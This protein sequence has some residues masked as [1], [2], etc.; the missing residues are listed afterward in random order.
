MSPNDF[1]Y[2]VYALGPMTDPCGTPWLN[3][4]GSDFTPYVYNPK[5]CGLRSGNSSIKRLCTV[6]ANSAK[7][8][9]MCY[10]LAAPALWN[11]LPENIRSAETFVT[12]KKSLKTFLFKK[13]LC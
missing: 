6:K 13:Y 11:P 1:V 10:S 9:Y 12:F 5:R 8:G 2:I 4:T 3:D 7:Y